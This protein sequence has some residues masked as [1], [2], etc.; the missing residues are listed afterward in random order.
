MNSVEQMNDLMREAAR[1]LDEQ[2]VSN[3]AMTMTVTHKQRLT[4]QVTG[5][6]EQQ[7]VASRA[8]EH[9]AAKLESATKTS[10]QT[11]AEIGVAAQSL[12]SS[13]SKVI[14]PPAFAQLTAGSRN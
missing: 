2:N 9:A 4:D 12:R 7:R 13:I 5:A 8:I 6:V 11:S 14:A 3:Q 10:L 1:S